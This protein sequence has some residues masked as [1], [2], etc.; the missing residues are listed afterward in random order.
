MRYHTIND[1]L[2]HKKCKRGNESIHSKLSNHH[3]KEEVAKTKDYHTTNT[4]KEKE[5]SKRDGEENMKAGLV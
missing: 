4:A 3:H 5:R 2:V 1:S